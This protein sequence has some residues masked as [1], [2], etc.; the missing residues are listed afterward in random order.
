MRL[1]WADQAY[2]GPC[3]LAMEPAA[4]AEHSPGDCQTA[5]GDQGV[6]A[7]AQTVDY[8]EVSTILLSY[9]HCL[10][11]SCNLI[12]LALLILTG[13]VF[14]RAVDHQITHAIFQRWQ[15]GDNLV[16]KPPQQN[17]PIPT[18]RC[19]QSTEMPFRN[20]AW[21]QPRQSFDRCLLLTN[22][23]ADQQPAED[24]VMAMAKHRPQ[25]LQPIGDVLGQTGELEHD[26]SPGR[27]DLAIV[28]ER[29]PEGS[30]LA[31]HSDR[32]LP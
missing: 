8:G 31:S 24:Q 10:S 14:Q 20:L 30:P 12:A 3:R 28:S 19:Q 26:G 22:C 4:L 29:K 32:R 23:L 16:G 17:P 5:E 9:M 18:R 13:F 1:I 6:P 15:C 2:G 25:H 21:G 11:Q 27:D 7:P